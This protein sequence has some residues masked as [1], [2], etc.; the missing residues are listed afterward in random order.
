LPGSSPLAAVYDICFCG[1]GNFMVISTHFIFKKETWLIEEEDAI[2]END[3]TEKVMEK[4][5][6]AGDKIN[7]VGQSDLF[8]WYR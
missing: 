4:A 2:S 3:E 7:Y 5:E 8:P 6:T 1:C